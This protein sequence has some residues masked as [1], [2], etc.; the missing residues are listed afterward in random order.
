MDTKRTEVTSE[1]IQEF[2][3]DA[4]RI[5]ES[6]PSHFIFNMDEMGHQEWAD[7]KEVPCL[8]LTEHETDI[9]NLPVP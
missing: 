6:V 8:I 1:Q 7:R 5:I 3:A 4:F 2:F 9:V